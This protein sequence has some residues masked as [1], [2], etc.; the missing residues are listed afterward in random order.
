M[1]TVELLCYY[2]KHIPIHILRLSS[3]A[4]YVY[5]Y[6]YVHPPLPPVTRYD[7]EETVEREDE[8]H[9]T[10]GLN[11][12]NFISQSRTNTFNDLRVYSPMVPF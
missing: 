10:F 6:I 3:Y 9:S 5:P 11:Y 1:E 8:A 12:I 2:C 7:D 4:V